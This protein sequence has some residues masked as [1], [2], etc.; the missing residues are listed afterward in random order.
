MSYTFAV[1]YR[2]VLGEVGL[3]F[4]VLFGRRVLV[5]FL[6]NQHLEGMS[7][8]GKLL[9]T[10][11]KIVDPTGI[12]SWGDVKESWDKGVSWNTALET[13]GA[14]PM[15]GKLGKLS[16]LGKVLKAPKVVGKS[17]EVI[18]DL[19]KA[20]KVLNTVGLTYRKL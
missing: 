15:L 19:D 8:A 18:N 17:L 11:I 9:H 5:H 12:T 7:E 4:L 6:R 16:K 1:I 2:V 20:K 10:A 3:S 14:L 13:A